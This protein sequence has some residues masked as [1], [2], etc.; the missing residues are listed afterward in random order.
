MEVAFTKY[1]GNLTPEE[2]IEIMLLRKSKQV[3]AS[4][5][6]FLLFIFSTHCPIPPFN[7]ESKPRL[8][9]SHWIPTGLSYQNPWSCDEALTSSRD[10]MWCG[11]VKLE[12]IIHYPPRCPSGAASEGL[13]G[14]WHG[15]CDETGR[16]RNTTFSWGET[17]V[18]DSWDV[19]G[20]FVWG[21]MMGGGGSVTSDLD[22]C[23][24]LQSERH[25][26]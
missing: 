19:N 7:A 24:W 3:V 10:P 20:V 13:E 18:I 4:G 6:S 22:L 14:S 21:L 16:W 26:A 23:V 15:P 2:H 9:P 11:A 12:R 17:L 1:A 8:S 5:L 25:H